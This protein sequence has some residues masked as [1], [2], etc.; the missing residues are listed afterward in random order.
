[1]KQNSK[2]PI[3]RYPFY[4]NIIKKK[5][6][7][8]IF[9]TT[10][11]AQLCGRLG[12]IVSFC[13]VLFKGAFIFYASAL[14]NSKEEK[15]NEKQLKHTNVPKWFVIKRND[16]C[17]YKNALMSLQLN[18]FCAKWDDEAIPPAGHFI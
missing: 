7:K 6:A 5:L 14:N 12:L 13:F 11:I 16:I 10:N 15:K 3:W 17:W 1:M 18:T 9:H 8:K 4:I 2:K